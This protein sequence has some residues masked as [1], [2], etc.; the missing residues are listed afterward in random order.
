MMTAGLTMPMAPIWLRLVRGGKG[1]SHLLVQYWKHPSGCGHD[2]NNEG[3]PHRP[4][5]SVLLRPLSDW[6]PPFSSRPPAASENARRYKPWPPVSSLCCCICTDR[7]IR[8][9]KSRDRAKPSC[10]PGFRA[11]RLNLAERPGRQRHHSHPPAHSVLA[12]TGRA[13]IT[14]GP[15][16][17]EWVGLSDWLRTALLLEALSCLH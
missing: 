7:R 11:G 16:Q 12:G 9:C 10:F 2:L 1:D 3:P 5:D 4:C 15:P 14:H 13:P 17:R 6:P 8:A